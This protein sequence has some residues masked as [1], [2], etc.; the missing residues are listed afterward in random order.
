MALKKLLYYWSLYEIS[1]RYVDFLKYLVDWY[2]FLAK[3]CF[4]I[5]NRW[6]LHMTDR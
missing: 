5:F 3:F 2:I 1:A 4:P 6:I